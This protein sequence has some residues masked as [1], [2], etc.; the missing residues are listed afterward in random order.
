MSFTFIIKVKLSEF[1]C[2]AIALKQ[3]NLEIVIFFHT[4]QQQIQWR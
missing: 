4:N 3:L 2:F 1:Q